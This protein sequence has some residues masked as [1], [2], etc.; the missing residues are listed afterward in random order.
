VMNA[1]TASESTPARMLQIP[2][3]RL[4]TTAANHGPGDH[5][6]SII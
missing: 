1:D 5:S 3:F 2:T 6:S 4:L